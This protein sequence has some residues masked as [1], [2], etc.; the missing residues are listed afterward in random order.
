M[1]IVLIRVILFCLSLK[2]LAMIIIKYKINFSTH[3]SLNPIQ[4]TKYQIN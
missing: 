1:I 2:L 4:V 3:L